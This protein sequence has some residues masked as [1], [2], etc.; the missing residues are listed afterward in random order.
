MAS[1]CM[2]DLAYEL[3]VPGSSCIERPQVVVVLI[4]QIPKV[5]GM[6]CLVTSSVAGPN[7]RTDFEN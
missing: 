7:T 1:L 6:W 4:Y 5:V 3:P 2:I